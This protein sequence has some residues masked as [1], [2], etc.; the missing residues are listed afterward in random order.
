VPPHGS[1]ANGVRSDSASS[2]ARLDKVHLDDRTEYVA[3][4]GDLDRLIGELRVLG[5]E[6]LLGG[7]KLV[8]LDLRWADRVTTR[9]I[10]A[11]AQSGDRLASRAGALIVIS[12]DPGVGPALA[13]LAGS[14]P[15]DVV[16]T[17][18]EALLVVDIPLADERVAP[19]GP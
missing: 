17:R 10:W 8:V 5:A 9:A 7:R 13:A 16:P 14:Y 4:V 11:L 1:S 12:E 18:E 6:T 15:P 19:W 2:P 3:V